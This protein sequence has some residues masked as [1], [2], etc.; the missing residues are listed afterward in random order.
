M[1]S[2]QLSSLP[3]DILHS[4]LHDLP[5]RD[6]IRTSVVSHRFA[7]MWRDALATSPVL[8]FTDCDF[9]SGSSQ[10]PARV[11]ATIE[12]YLQR[13]FEKGAPLY[14]LRVV[15]DGTLLGGVGQDVVRWVVSVV[16]RGAREVEVDLTPIRRDGVAVQQ[17]ADNN[18]IMFLVLPVNLFVTRNSLVRL[19]L[20]RFS[21]RTVPASAVGLTGLQSLSLSRA[22]VT[23]EGIQTV[24]SNCHSLEFLSL[25]RCHLLRSVRIIGDKLRRLEIVSCLAVQQLRVLAP[26][27]E[28]LVFHGDIVRNLDDNF[29]AATDLGATPLLQDAYLSHIGFNEVFV[30][31]HD[32]CNFIRCISHARTL[33]ICSVGLMQ[34]FTEDGYDANLNIDMTNVQELQLLM[35]S[36]DLINLVTMSGLFKLNPLPLLDRLFVRVFFKPM[37]DATTLLNTDLSHTMEIYFYNNNFVFGHLRLIKVVNLWGTMMELMMLD[38]LLSQAP[39]LE[40]VVLVATDEGGGPGDELLEAFQDQVSMIRMASR[41]VHI[42][43]CRPS[44]DR[45]E[46]ATH[47]RFYHEV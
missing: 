24:L 40:H 18:E 35:A 42:T 3:D 7:K 6:I 27:L 47:S 32:Y 28:S 34:M 10:T 2:D 23:D 41:D 4:I 33:T 25:R 11:V 43:V 15:L 9:V 5:L 45:S 20:D 1:V 16:A 14:V 26:A 38:F 19:A 31:N 39:V 17:D 44:E 8:D 21:L 12:R 30:I 22:D 46:N 36:M 29:I 37:D 13:H